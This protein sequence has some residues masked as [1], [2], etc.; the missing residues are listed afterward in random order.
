MNTERNGSGSDTSPGETA[1][2]T[3]NRTGPRWWTVLLLATA[4]AFAGAAGTDIYNRLQAIPVENQP[5]TALLLPNART[6]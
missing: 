2:A 6:W 4:T 3:P 5:L 1:Q